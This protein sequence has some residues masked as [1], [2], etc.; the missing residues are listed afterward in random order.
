MY[1]YSVLRTASFVK[2]NTQ[3]DLTSFLLYFNTS[4][5]PMYQSESGVSSTK[6]F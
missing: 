6:C 5:V 2:Q 1:Q 3:K 4:K